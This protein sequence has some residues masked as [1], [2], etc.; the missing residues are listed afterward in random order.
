MSCSRLSAAHS[1]LLFEEGRPRADRRHARA[2]GAHSEIAPQP[3]DPQTGGP[4]IRGRGY[5]REP[6]ATAAGL[7]GY[8]S[9]SNAWHCQ[10][11][12]SSRSPTVRILPRMDAGLPPLVRN[13]P[14]RDCSA[15]PLHPCI[16]VPPPS[17]AAGRQVLD[18]AEV[19]RPA[20]QRARVPA[21]CSPGVDRQ[22]QGECA[23]HR[24]PSC[25]QPEVA[26]SVRRFK[27]GITA[28]PRVRNALCS[29]SRCSAV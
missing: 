12:A 26:P 7:T 28:L 24:A 14:S 1:A 18:V 27:Y 10:R 25:C 15:V 8:G 6:A 23:S 21:G 16:K 2:D 11:P 4:S 19:V 3:A 13:S 17:S 20:E 9:R 22:H 29:S 5:R